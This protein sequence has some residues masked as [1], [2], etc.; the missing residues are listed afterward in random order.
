MMS[1]KELF[2]F[3]TDLTITEQ[4]IEEYLDKAQERACLRP[5]DDQTAEEEIAEAV[6]QKVFI[7][8]TL[9][10]VDRYE[11]DYERLREGGGGGDA[12]GQIGE[13]VVYRTITGMN[14]DLTGPRSQPQLLQGTCMVGYIPGAYFSIPRS[15]LCA[16][17]S[18]SWFLSLCRVNPLL[19]A[20]P[21]GRPPCIVATHLGPN[22]A[23]MH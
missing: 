10:E 20:T 4:N 18:A 15:S 2:D 22:C 5:L 14:A 23:T 13:D 19:K 1:S 11:E 7:P 3:I 17:F 21:D 9:D 12:G 6:F 8:R 16:F